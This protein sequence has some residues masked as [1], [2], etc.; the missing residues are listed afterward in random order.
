MSQP[1]LKNF[2]FE[3]IANPIPANGHGSPQNKGHHKLLPTIH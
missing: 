3:V 2:C 1:I